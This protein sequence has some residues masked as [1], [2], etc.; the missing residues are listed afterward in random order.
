MNKAI[1]ALV[2]VAGFSTGAMAAEFKGY[3][4]D[5][6]CSTKAAMKGNAECA[7]KCIKGGSPAVLV[8]DD[9][10]VYKIADQA[11]VTPMA[12]KQVTINGTMTGDTITVASIK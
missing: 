11:K 9:G 4:I 6:Q 3:I 5:Q 10:K 7:A 8:T 2:L 12:G 1:L